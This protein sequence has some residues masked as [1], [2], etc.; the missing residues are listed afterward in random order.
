MRM[1]RG[2]VCGNPQRGPSGRGLISA[3]G[4]PWVFW[5]AKRV[6]P[7]SRS[8]QLESESVGVLNWLPLV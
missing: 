7:V 8:A 5:V 1:L 3:A 4:D 2:A 6:R